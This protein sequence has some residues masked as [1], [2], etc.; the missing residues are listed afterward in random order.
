VRPQEEKS[1][2]SQEREEPHNNSQKRLLHLRIEN[3]IQM[4]CNQM[5]IQEEILKTDMDN[6]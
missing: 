6:S 5:Q 4:M 3:N 1:G 2:S